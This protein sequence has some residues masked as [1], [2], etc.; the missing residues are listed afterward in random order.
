MRGKIEE[1]FTVLHF[2]WLL[3]KRQF[4]KVSKEILGHSIVITVRPSKKSSILIEV[5]CD[6]CNKDIVEIDC[7]PETR[8]NDVFTWIN[9]H[10]GFHLVNGLQKQIEALGWKFS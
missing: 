1:C 9:E 4:S 3:S 5:K 6:T 2:W 7:E 10:I 8:L